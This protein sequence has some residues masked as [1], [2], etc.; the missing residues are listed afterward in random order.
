MQDNLNCGMSCEHHQ[1]GTPLGL[2]GCLCKAF[3]LNSVWLKMEANPLRQAF[4]RACFSD[5]PEAFF[6]A[7]FSDPPDRRAVFRAAASGASSSV[8]R[9][10]GANPGKGHNLYYMIFETTAVQIKIH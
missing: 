4:F 3:A 2:Q 9:C 8:A 1:F 6:R 10:S 5:P 7:C